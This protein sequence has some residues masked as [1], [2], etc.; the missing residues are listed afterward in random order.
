MMTRIKGAKE[1]GSMLI[2]KRCKS[3]MGDDYDSNICQSKGILAYKTH[4]FR[5]CWQEGYWGNTG[6]SEV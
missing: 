3:Q 2:R 1:S 6:G 4:V 5:C